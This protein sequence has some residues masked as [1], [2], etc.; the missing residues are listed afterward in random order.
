MSPPFSNRAP[1]VDL[2]RPAVLIDSDGNETQVTVLDLSARGFRL[3]VS[4]SPR[5]AEKVTL[6]V[7]RDQEFPAE[8]RWTLG[9]EAGGVFRAPPTEIGWNSSEG[10]AARMDR[11]D[12][13]RGEDRR[14]GVDRR[15][16]PDR[17]QGG[18]TDDRR[19]GDRRKSD[20]RG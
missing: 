3:H 7:E 1:R 20:R 12:S 9:N 16:G 2:R 5:V 17:R 10:G 13:Q 4:E 6:R 15:Q 8:I 11:P 14:E 18:R 19:L